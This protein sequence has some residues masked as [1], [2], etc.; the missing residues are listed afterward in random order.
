MTY[1]IIYQRKKEEFIED[2]K[3]MLISYVELKEYNSNEEFV[4]SRSLLAKSEEYPLHDV[5]EKVI[6]TAEAILEITR[7]EFDELSKLYEND[8]KEF[9]YYKAV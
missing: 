4:S 3:L 2:E 7:A 1:K 5:P 8:I 6:N 9:V